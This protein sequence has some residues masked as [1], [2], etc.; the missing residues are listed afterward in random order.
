M[1]VTLE[2][3]MSTLNSPSSVRAKIG[4]RNIDKL[5]ASAEG[6]M[7]GR[8]YR[9]LYEVKE[10]LVR[11]P[12]VEEENVQ[13]AAEKGDDK[14]MTPKRKRHDLG[15]DEDSHSHAPIGHGSSAFRG[16]RP[17]VCFLQKKRKIG[18][19]LLLLKVKWIPLYSLKCWFRRI[20]LLWRI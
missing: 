9:F 5:P 17:A 14:T 18:N 6:C 16:A 4:C 3:D 10:V 19:C 7:G 12:V 13:V 20:E 11:N 1:G 15:N 8:F 2:V